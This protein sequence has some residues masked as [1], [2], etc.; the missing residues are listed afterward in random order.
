LR[1]RFQTDFWLCEAKTAAGE[2]AIAEDYRS[3]KT[4]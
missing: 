3:G 1:R 2:N 4:L